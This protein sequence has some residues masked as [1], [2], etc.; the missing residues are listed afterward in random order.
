VARYYP[1]FVPGHRD[2]GIE[3]ERLE[4]E[5]CVARKIFLPCIFLPSLGATGRTGTEVTRR[6]NGKMASKA[7]SSTAQKASIFAGGLRR[8][9]KSIGG[10]P[11][12]YPL[13]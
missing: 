1:A 5:K 6:D 3:A 9:D 11:I 7:N 12:E 10:R 2:K 8:L 13:L 4:A